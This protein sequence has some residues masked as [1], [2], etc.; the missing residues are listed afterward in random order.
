MTEKWPKNIDQSRNDSQHRIMKEVQLRM[1]ERYPLDINCHGIENLLYLFLFENG[2]LITLE[3]GETP[4]AY[5]S[6]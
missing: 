4:V 6:V 5:C 1:S 2:C 3:G